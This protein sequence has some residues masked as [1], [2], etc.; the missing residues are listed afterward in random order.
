MSNLAF[1]AKQLAGMSEDLQAVEKTLAQSERERWLYDCSLDRIPE[2]VAEG[3]LLAE[4]F[5]MAYAVVRNLDGVFAL[6]AAD[7]TNKASFVRVIPCP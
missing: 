7:A 4:K 2:L 1:I 6:C 3:E 5:S